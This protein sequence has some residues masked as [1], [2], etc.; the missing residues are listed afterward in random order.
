MHSVVV[1][2]V[3]ATLVVG[4]GGAKIIQDVRAKRWAWAAIGLVVTIAVPTVIAMAQSRE[5]K[6]SAV[7]MF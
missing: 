3:L 5:R 2:L 6:S 4:Y 1:L 7:D